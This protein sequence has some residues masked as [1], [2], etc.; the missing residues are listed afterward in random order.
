MT[1]KQEEAIQAS[2]IASVE[3]EE[4]RIK[5]SEQRNIID[6]AKSEL[7]NLNAEFNDLNNLINRNL[8]LVL[9]KEKI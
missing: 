3:L 1:K 6:T 4:V 8:N 9:M 5:I 2:L 7:W